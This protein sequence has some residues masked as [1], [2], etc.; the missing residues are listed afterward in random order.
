VPDGPLRGGPEPYLLIPEIS[1]I[2]NQH[3][4]DQMKNEI[5]LGLV[6]FLW[7]SGPVFS[8]QE[9]VQE[10]RPKPSLGL[11]I[12][13]G[14]LLVQYVRLG[15]TYDLYADSGIALVIE[16]RDSTRRTYAVTTS[17]PSQVGSKEWLKGYLE[18]PDPSWFWLEKAE[19]TVE[20]QSKQQVKMYLKIPE[21]EK[22]YNQHW[23]I[24]L[25]VR[26]KPA[27]GMTM[28]LAVCPRYQIETMAKEGMKVRP[29]GIIAFEPS[30][31]RLETVSPG[32]TALART[33]LYNNDE[34]K[35]EYKI[36][37]QIFPPDPKKRQ[38]TISPGYAWLPDT[39]W[40]VPR[41]KVVTVEPSGSLPL[42][43][44]VKIP[45]EERCYGKKWEVIL[46]VEPDSGPAGF[47]RLQ[48]LTKAAE[49]AVPEKEKPTSP[50]TSSRSPP[51]TATGSSKCPK[52][53]GPT[54]ACL[55]FLALPLTYWR[56]K[57]EPF[58]GLLCALLLA[59]LSSPAP[60]AGL[61]TTFVKPII[62]GIKIGQSYNITKKNNLPL[63]IVN[64]GDR[65]MKVSV[66]PV[67]PQQSALSKGYEPIPDLSWVK[68][69]ENL[70][71][72]APKAIASTDVIIRIPYDPK[73]AGKNYEV[74]IWSKG[75]AGMI[76]VGLKSRILINISEEIPPEPE[77]PAL[78]LSLLPRSHLLQ[79][80]PVGTT[81]SS[82]ISIKLENRSRKAHTYILSACKP[83]A[84]GENWPEGYSE[85]PDAGWIRFEQA[86]LKVGPTAAVRTKMYIL[87]P[88]DA[89]Y[90]NQHWVA[91][92]ALWDLSA[93]KKPVNLLLHPQYFIETNSKAGL[94]ASLYGTVALS[95]TK[96][97]L[98]NAPLGSRIKIDAIKIF[99]NR[100]ENCSYA[101]RS[102]AP[103]Q[104]GEKGIPLSPG[105]E[106]IPVPG[107]LFAG[108]RMFSIENH[109]SA[110][111][112]VWLNIPK[113]LEYCD[114]KWEGLLLVRSDK[115]D[116]A[117]ARV[118]ITTQKKED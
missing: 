87:I 67:F 51:G 25:L 62:R 38:I 9:A 103:A 5:F 66:E 56:R 35:H 91:R 43:F 22:Y 115:G 104:G 109:G 8:E 26:G 110:K 10:G 31:R 80:I 29:D 19:V 77:D 107:W 52:P 18:I 15:Q 16:N 60:C 49:S 1:C 41:E 57:P 100:P 113:K 95:P 106:K 75:A 79:D 86:E 45:D 74:M 85:I 32:K 34:N 72:I 97:V 105:Y 90:V 76:G 58:C 53:L 71:T 4:R 55:I 33:K 7:L 94:T 98:K 112:D 102:R 118:Q 101:V 47:V 83:A 13:P 6:A 82:P 44:D 46:F 108:Q 116:S 69:G 114:K 93:D 70:L 99:N 64:K 37:V 30:L 39:K 20:A 111:T 14:G 84:I 68:V 96:L 50:S 65:E 23:S 54:P 24:S 3:T 12:R 17:K 63:A 42:L 88:P 81:Y 89:K 27:P 48:V 117:F 36:S 28:G 11:S 21:E 2:T 92:L 61:S 59:L 78:A 40:V 73:Y